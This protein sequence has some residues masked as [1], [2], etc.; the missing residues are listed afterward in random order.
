MTLPVCTQS[1]AKGAARIEGKVG[2]IRPTRTT[3]KDGQTGSHEEEANEER[4]AENG[5]ARTARRAG[6]CLVSLRSRFSFPHLPL[7]VGAPSIRAL[8]RV[9]PRR[10]PI[11]HLAVKGED[12]PPCSGGPA[13]GMT[14]RER[15]P[16]RNARSG[17][18][19]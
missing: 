17:D 7:L 2:T 10:P 8:C 5:E 9:L 18:R 19:A 11:H 3:G 13:W 15:I 16:G 4:R 1:S 14:A 6:A 12:N